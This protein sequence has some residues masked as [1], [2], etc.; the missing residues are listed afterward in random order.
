MP[1]FQKR[2]GR[3]MLTTLTVKSGETI[4]TRKILGTP[5]DIESP[6]LIVTAD[7]KRKF[8]A[9]NN[10]GN[11]LSSIKD[12]NIL[13]IELEKFVGEVFRSIVP[14]M[15]LYCSQTHGMPYLI[16]AF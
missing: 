9:G 11:I 4:F 10:V 1:G 14:A 7:K 13:K 16:I 8:I 6:Y 3:I 5:Q 15:L 2:F 12:S